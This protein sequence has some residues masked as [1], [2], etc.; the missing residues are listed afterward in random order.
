[1]ESVEARRLTGDLNVEHGRADPFAATRPL[2]AYRRPLRV[3]IVED[4]A[5]LAMQLD[6]LLMDA[7]HEVVGWAMTADEAMQIFHHA[8]PD[9]AFVDLQLG[10]GRTGIDVAREIR[11]TNSSATDGS[12]V[13]FVTANA[14]MLPEDFAGA[15][16]VIDKPYSMQ[17][18]EAALSYLHECIRTPPPCCAVPRSLTLAP[19]YRERWKVA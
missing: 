9:L 19:A 5:L 8:K 11:A 3:L 1:M 7:G 18:I 17:G 14:N 2:M 6:V 13:V 4:E 16:G 12:V 15:I 10:G